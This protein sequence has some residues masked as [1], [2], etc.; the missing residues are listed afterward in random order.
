[1]EAGVLFAAH[2]FPC[3]L[4]KYDISFYQSVNGIFMTKEEYEALA[5]F[6]YTLR[7]FLQF[8]RKA[9]AEQGLAPQQYLALL[10][11]KSYER[12]TVGKLA[13]RLHV[14][15]HSA[16][17]L[18]NRLQRG[19]LVAREPSDKDRRCI[20]VSLT[21]KGEE[22]LSRLTSTHRNEL[23]T[24]GPLL[25]ELLKNINEAPEVAG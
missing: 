13:E 4:S 3:F 8:S 15:P 18:V 24:A 19:G 21:A 9:A 14:A 10:E 7:K 12:V 23:K 20:H 11:I 16:V 17:G 6:R 22:V 1:M 5:S 25:V 2:S